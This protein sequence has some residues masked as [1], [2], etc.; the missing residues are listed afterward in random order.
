MKRKV[1]KGILTA[2]IVLTSFGFILGNLSMANASGS[3]SGKVT[4]V[5]GQPI[6][7]VW[8]DAS[9]GECGST[10][11]GSSKTDVQGDYLINLPAGDY[12]VST[13]SDQTYIDEW[14]NNGDGTNNCNEAMLT[15]VIEGQTASGINF[16]LRGKGEIS[17]KIISNEDQ[18]IVNVKVDATSLCGETFYG[19]GTS[20]ENG[21]YL[22]SDLPEGN[23]YVS[24]YSENYPGEWWTNEEGTTDCNAA[25]QVTVVRGETV[26]EINFQLGAGEISGTVTTAGGQAIPNIRVEATSLCGET[27]YGEGTTD[28]TGAYSIISLRPGTYYI[29][30]HDDNKDYIGKWW[31]SGGG[32]TDCDEAGQVGVTEGQNVSDIN[33]S[34]DEPGKISV[35]V[36]TSSGQ[37]IPEIQV[38]ATGLC[39]ETWYGGGK[40]DSG[41]NCLISGLLPGNYYISSYD[42]NENYVDEWWDGGNGTSDCNKAGQISV[43]GGQ[44]VSV[45]VPLDGPGKISG[46]V[47]ATNGQP[48][49]D[50]SVNAWDLCNAAW[51][52]GTVTGSDG[53][54]LIPGLLPGITYYIS[55][56]D[57]DKIYTGEWWDGGDGTTD[58]K[59]AASLT[60]TAGQTTS[61]TDFVLEKGGAISGKV[62]TSSGSSDIWVSASGICEGTF[63]GRVEV[64]TAGNYSLAGLSPGDYYISTED[65]NGKY[66]GKWWNSGGGTADC[67]EA[68]TVTVV[69]G[70]TTSGINF[71]LTEN[72]MIS[73]KITATG[74]DQP[75]SDVCVY[76]RDLCGEDI[77]G[78]GT[79]DTDGNY[80]ISGIR[81]GD[82]YVFTY[83]SY[84]T[85]QN[86]V[87]EWWD[88]GD[89]TTDCN[90]AASVTVTA[91]QTTPD[92][93]FQLAPGSAISGKVTT[94]GGQVIPNIKVNAWDL[95]MENWYGEGQ[96]DADGKYLISGLSEGDY[97][98]LTDTSE[99]QQNH[100]DEWWNNAEG[101]TDCNEAAPVT[102]VTGQITADIDFILN[103]GGTISG[104]ITANNDQ[105]VSN[106]CVGASSSLCGEPHA[107]SQTDDEGN[108][109][110]SGLS[111]GTYYLVTDV[112]CYYQQGYTDK[113]WNN[114]KGTTDCNNSEQIT[115][116]SGQE[117]SGINFSLNSPQEIPLVLGWNWISFNTLPEDKLMANVLS[118]YPAQNNDVIKTA[119]GIATYYEGVWYGLSEGIKAGVMYLLNTQSSNPGNLNIE[120]HAVDVSAPVTIRPGWNWIGFNPQKSMRIAAALSSLDPSDN[121]M[122][123]TTPSQGGT[124][125]YY[126]GQWWP[127]DYK[128]R[129]GVGYL[130]KSSLFD[131]LN[132]PES[133]NPD[134]GRRHTRSV[135]KNV[136]SVPNWENPTGMHYTATIHAKVL[137]DNGQFVDADGSKLAA[138]KD[139][140]CRGMITI[141][142]GPAG[143]WFQLTVAS[144]EDGE[145]G[146][147]L[148]AY[149]AETEKIYDI[150]ETV[151]FVVDETIGLI[152]AP[153]VYTAE[154]DI[155]YEFTLADAI[156]AL[157]VLCGS[158]I[159]G[160]DIK[161]GDVN[162]DSKIG[163]E[164]V[165]SVLWKISASKD[166]QISDE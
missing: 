132:Y 53:S 87:N 31:K 82:Y 139:D 38:N 118:D 2:I 40:T 163:L 152:S 22:I 133:D 42:E 157:K 54:Y 19:S 48:I 121:D 150:Q 81:P 84:V 131:T 30:T 93:S 101:T 43:T 98:I 142:P 111:P 58:C 35:T 41:G 77:Y 138:F 165:I 47:T 67:S 149:D 61:G 34:L 116:T 26:S 120:G 156:I 6:P 13:S 59:E 89:G 12:Y 85:Q 52:S 16:G 18:P 9:S 64:D 71:S 135:M 63:Y 46:K 32:T 92:I 83:V 145:S 128:L 108:Y 153:A 161:V 56:Y 10:W 3:I 55:A 162:G 39:G 126:G 105:P 140:E 117:T 25:G 33:F 73:G 15:T 158:D 127:A 148:K 45:S 28:A 57:G 112:S 94:G 155:M 88:N 29:S 11:H 23:Y 62:S 164:E 44:T 109:L 1:E 104:K 100:T 68:A 17:G 75:I 60:V 27:W 70:E 146:L 130:L 129:P 119:E 134:T 154:A 86:Y 160:E 122:V 115:V 107:G 103:E 8:V 14:W 36:T 123:K 7:N 50:I 102:V 95:C 141:D 20:D 151:D 21:N 78:Q 5:D 106:V 159:N 124:A 125:T 37:A 96:T 91:G 74:D 66:A 69:T 76:V 72:G 137:L 65:E 49:A 147:V 97:F 113:W 79:T 4:T 110:I 80:L 166:T 144:N 114:E 143:K 90:G 99:S 24:T 136:R 51:Y